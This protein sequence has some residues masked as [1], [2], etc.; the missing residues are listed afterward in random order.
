MSEML[1]GFIKAEIV[2][3]IK[4]N[5]PHMKYSPFLYAKVIDAVHNEN[6]RCILRILDKNK[7]VDDDFPDI[8]NV[9]TE[10]NIETGDI[11]IVGLLYGEL[12]PV[13]IERYM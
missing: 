5:Y 11:V 8:P 1:S 2:E 6:T 3:Q 4:K 9:L 7:G 13:I 12:N 10:K